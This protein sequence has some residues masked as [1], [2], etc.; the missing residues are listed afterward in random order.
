VFVAKFVG[1]TNII[2]GNAISTSTSTEIETPIGRFSV[3]EKV[4]GPVQILIRSDSAA[5]N[6]D[7]FLLTGTTENLAF[8]GGWTRMTVL[9]D[10]VELIFDFDSNSTL[11]EV[12]NPVTVGIDIEKG[13]QIF[14]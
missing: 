8:R 14:T 12:G 3:E 6:G 13:L 11:P 10:G 1:L 5:L 2:E 4:A 9:A 7:G